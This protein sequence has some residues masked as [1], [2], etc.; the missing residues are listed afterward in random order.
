M[1]YNCGTCG[2]MHE[3]WPA[4]C[5]KAPDNYVQ[6]SKEDKEK[7][8]TTIN[9]DLCVIKYKDQ[10]D[11]FIR[12]VLFQQIK[13]HEHDLEYGVWVSLSEKSFNDY[14]ANYYE[15][16]H[17]AVYFAYLCNQ[18]PEYGP[19]TGIKANVMVP[20]G[21]SRPEV[22]PHDNQIDSEFVRDYYEG[23]TIEEAERRIG[24][25]LHHTALRN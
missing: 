23:I 11:R 4:L 8:V 13:D 12:C 6:L 2:K 10:T 24:H 18:F 3:D 20:K 22:I 19:M 16:E 15:E 25:L 17:E 7:Y 9:D 1:A 14:T 21:S 5:F